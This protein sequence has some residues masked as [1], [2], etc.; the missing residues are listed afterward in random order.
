MNRKTDNLS[1]HGNIFIYVLRSISNHIL[2]KLIRFFKILFHKYQ[3]VLSSKFLMLYIY[4]SLSVAKTTKNL[5][6]SSYLM[7]PLILLLNSAHVEVYLIK[8][9][10]NIHPC[11][12]I[13]LTF[14]THTQTSAGSRIHADFASRLFPRQLSSL[15]LTY[16]QAAARR[17]CPRPL[18]RTSRRA[19]R[20]SREREFKACT[21]YAS[22][23]S[24]RV[25]TSCVC[26]IYTESTYILTG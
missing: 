25:S 15:S 6:F 23:I 19:G 3:S 12:Y 16:Y 18:A 14:H 22:A 4:T 13:S 7:Q 26:C 17:R 5:H 1:P 10:T 11:S 2:I 9:S 21:L 24:P 20:V 8:T